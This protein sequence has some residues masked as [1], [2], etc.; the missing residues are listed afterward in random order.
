M[1]AAYLLAVELIQ[2][3]F[4]DL[5]I[6]AHLLGMPSDAQGLKLPSDEALLPL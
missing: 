2:L 5:H 6:L 1:R 3:F 4:G